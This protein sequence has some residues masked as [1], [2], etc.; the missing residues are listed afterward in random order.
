MKKRNISKFCISLLLLCAMIM[1]FTACTARVEASNMLY[2]V[3]ANQVNSKPIDDAFIS[4]S[5]DFAIKVFQKSIT[6]DENSLISPLSVMLALS[7]VAN[8]ANGQ[9]KSEM[10]TL[11]GSNI[12]I[13]DLNQY[14][15]SYVQSLPSSDKYK[16]KIANSI[17]FHDDENQFRVEKDFLQKNA[18]YY[19]A[20]T[21]KSSFSKETLK[22]IN[23]WVKNRTNGMIDKIINEIDKDA[24]MYLINAL[25]FEAEWDTVYEKYNV[26]NGEFNTIKGITRSVKMMSSSESQYI[27]TGKATG[28]IKNYKDRKY[29]FVALLPNKDVNINEYVSSLDGEGFRL[30]VA[31]AKPAVVSAKLPKFRYEY[32]VEMSDI[33]SLLGIPTAFDVDLA[34]FSKLGSY[35]DGKIYIENVIHKTYISVDEL[36]TKAGAVTSI[37]VNASSAPA[38]IKYVTLDRPFIYAIIDNETK[39]PFFIG[40]VMDIQK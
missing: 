21:Y 37:A 28:F 26:A 38:E 35:T 22:D 1:N 6:K 7:M 17:W 16:L 29:S 33:L 18:D 10:E 36:G 12:S 23:N 25:V 20:A 13:E 11:L 3:T 2:S 40:T 30:A 9:T 19:N 31:N 4:S 27:D 39:L 24:V 8:G 15:Y 34:D 14:L 5:A 32:S